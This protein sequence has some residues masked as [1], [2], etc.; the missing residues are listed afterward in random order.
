MRWG[1]AA[2]ETRGG[3]GTGLGRVC[4]HRDTG[5]RVHKGTVN[6]SVVLAV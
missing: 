3:K 4:G 5:S 2:R 1:E 6:G